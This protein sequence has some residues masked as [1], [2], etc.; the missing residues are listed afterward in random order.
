MKILLDILIIG[1]ISA[2][3]EGPLLRGTV[4]PDRGGSGPLHSMPKQE[5]KIIPAP[6]SYP[7]TCKS[8]SRST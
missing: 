5:L 2:L 3:L 7:K 8:F 4:G 1:K 6:F